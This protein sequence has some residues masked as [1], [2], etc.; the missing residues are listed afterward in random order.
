MGLGNIGVLRP[1]VLARITHNPALT[2][3][4]YLSGDV[5]GAPS[6]TRPN[7]DG[8]LVDLAELSV[9]IDPLTR[10]TSVGGVS[11][12]VLDDGSIREATAAS[13]M[14]GAQIEILVGDKLDAESAYTQVFVGT[15]M[16]ITPEEGLVK[17]DAEGAL[18]M[19]RDRD[20]KATDFVNSS[21]VVQRHPLQIIEAILDAADLP[22]SL[23]D[24]AS[25]DPD[26]F[27]SGPRA[28]SHWNIAR[29]VHGNFDRSINEPVSAFQLI[30]QL[31]NLMDGA[32]VPLTDGRLS[33]RQFDPSA[34][35]VKTFDDDEIIGDIEQTAT[36][37]NLINHARILFGWKGQ[38]ASADEE[39]WLRIASGGYVRNLSQQDYLFQVARQ[40]STSVTDYAFPTL[41]ERRQMRQF[42]TKWVGTS[43][44]VI[45][46]IS[47][48]S[49]PVTV[50]CF[51][52]HLASFTGVERKLNG[53]SDGAAN[54]TLNAPD[55][56]AFLM[57]F[58]A[59]SFLQSFEI[60]RATSVTEFPNIKIITDNDANGLPNP[61][62]NLAV[63][64]VDFVCDRAQLGT[65]KV[66]HTAAI[67][68]DGFPPGARPLSVVDITIAVEYV[69]NVL[70]RFSNGLPI[71]EIDVHLTEENLGLELMDIVALNNN[72]FL[73]R[74]NDGVTTQKFEIVGKRLH[75][76]DD[77]PRVALTLAFANDPT[78]TTLDFV[79]E[80]VGKKFFDGLDFDTDGQMM[81]PHSTGGLE[82]TGTGGLN[83]SIGAGAN[84]GSGGV[85]YAG[86]STF[87]L[88]DA[89]NNHFVYDHHRQLLIH[90]SEAAV[91]ILTP[92]HH[93]VATMVTA[94][95]VITSKRD[96]RRGPGMI[97][98]GRTLGGANRFTP[99][100]A[101]D[102]Y[103]RPREDFLPNGLEVGDFGTLGTDIFV[104]QGVNVAS[105]GRSIQM[106]FDGGG[107]GV[108]PEVV[109]EYIFPIQLGHVYRATGFF[110]ASNNFAAPTITVQYFD[111]EF[112]PTGGDD[113]VTLTKTP[114]VASNA[115]NA[116]QVLAFPS[117]GG[118]FR[119][120]RVRFRATAL[121]TNT[122]TV[123]LDRLEFEEVNPS[124]H[125]FL[126]GDQAIGSTGPVPILFDS[127]AAAGLGFNNGLAFSTF[128]S[129]WFPIIEGR[130]I[131]GVSVSEESISPGN[132]RV[133]LQLDPTG[134]SGFTNVKSFF[135]I[136]P[137][138]V[139][140]EQSGTTVI[141]AQRGNVFRIVTDT[142]LDGSY[143]INGDS[144]GILTNWWA[145][146][147]D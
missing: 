64:R 127:V 130:Y 145:I 126:T 7:P 111:E 133:R 138:G 63:G 102:L 98:S 49:D 91:P 103:T 56:V 28:M 35:P 3:L 117:Q 129:R 39:P 37:A 32:L 67:D 94:G 10:K 131:T 9:T 122:G 54:F 105:G 143:T 120:A 75:I 72:V 128:S 86:I 5:E 52:G 61:D 27:S 14:F 8:E 99:N 46:D 92:D 141:T 66:A 118:T 2:V 83:V 125:A 12:V 31:L 82:V 104:H 40:D 6:A 73:N 16:E 78:L 69:Q 48:T 124:F 89:A 112:R 119:Y 134:A 51:G 62:E 79:L 45:S 116:I 113:S 71:V 123:Y 88:T 137:S 55:R 121:A 146:R 26:T 93:L 74:G 90:S 41:P 18:N 81:E 36:F 20:L 107:G 132:W 136:T 85:P 15:I 87:A 77:E 11:I 60:M 108:E 59:S 142:V 68:A 42:E 19:I 106:D 114:V 50:K 17:I 140:K 47:G 53:V 135:E 22:S 109:T 144:I 44:T 70:K 110:I 13:P 58:R 139:V 21:S 1:R 76:L 101:F 80:I 147:I 38:H 100:A 30:D 65:S 24:L 96:R 95:G 115:I 25:L 29:G 84:V 43:S 33:F 34:T 23:I 57:I 97:V 4:R